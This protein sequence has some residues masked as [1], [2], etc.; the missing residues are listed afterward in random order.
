MIDDEITSND[1]DEEYDEG[2]GE[3]NK[4]VRIMGCI[5]EEDES[6]NEIGNDT[7]F[8]VPKVTTSEN[9]FLTRRLSGMPLL[10]EDEQLSSESK[11]RFTP[12]T[13][14]EFDCLLAKFPLPPD[15]R[16]LSQQTT[17]FT[18]GNNLNGSKTPPVNAWGS[19]KG[20]AEK[21]YSFNK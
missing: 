4:K 21:L 2:P 19:F 6:F 3:N 7:D 5:S 13:A 10:L 18:G 11:L 14:K 12:K 8:E 15:D 1:S 17:P 16:D 9:L 20:F